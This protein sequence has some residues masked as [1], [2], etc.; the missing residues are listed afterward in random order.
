MSFYM[1]PSDTAVDTA[2]HTFPVGDIPTA[3][4]YVGLG[5]GRSAVDTGF[6]SS[7]RA[8]WVGQRGTS[9]CAVQA[10]VNFV[11]GR[12][13]KDR[14]VLLDGDWRLA[15]RV[16]ESGAQVEVVPWRASGDRTRRGW[17]WLMVGPYV[18]AAAGRVAVAAKDCDLVCVN[19]SQAVAV[20]A[21]AAWRA[22]KP[23]VWHLTEVL[24]PGHFRGANRRPVVALAN[25]AAAAVV[26][27]TPVVARS[28]VE[29][30]GRRD[31]LR[32]VPQGVDASV[33]DAVKPEALARRR[34]EI[35]AS[36]LKVVG[37]FGP[38]EAS[39]GHS[40][41]IEAVAKDPRLMAVVV[42]GVVPGQDAYRE[43]LHDLAWRH[44]V[45]D[46]VRFLGPR[47]DVPA[48][49]KACDMVVCCSTTP[50]PFAREI[51]QGLLAG[52]PVVATEVGCSELV[53]HQMH[54]L[55]VP[56]DDVTALLA[57]IHRYIDEPETALRFAQEGQYHARVAL[58]RQAMM[59][60]GNA[61]FEEAVEMHR[62]TRSSISD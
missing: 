12:G 27:P 37:I 6:A 33:F 50:E 35:D 59:R 19:T 3:A 15:E 38:L 51:I 13:G 16:R 34:W 43:S 40:V 32:R 42:G 41:L 53:H 4:E 9:D 31:L 62:K 5:A 29:A 44:G 61:V 56:A 60:G 14:V 36:G 25:Y 45:A 54:C 48:L 18:W 10:M 28:F 26:V 22:K 1:T 55:L 57:A 21:V 58:S 2:P 20:A 17:S 11:S 8:L 49:M 30:G 47:E 7:V 46:R 52:R 23:W 39:Q 24:S